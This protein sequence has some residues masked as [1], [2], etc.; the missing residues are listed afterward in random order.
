MKPPERLAADDPR[1]WLNRAKSNLRLARSRV[2]GVYLEDLCFEAQQAAEKA[3]KALMIHRGIDFPYIHD[4]GA[5]LSLLAEAGEK[6]PSTVQ[7][8][9]KLTPYAATVRY[10]GIAERITDGEHSEAVRLAEGVVE[11]VDGRL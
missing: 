8:A 6:I 5:L 9:R 4:L 10:P 2:E 3:I 7:Q 11:W 1:E